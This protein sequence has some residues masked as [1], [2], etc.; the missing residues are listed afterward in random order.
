MPSNFGL[1]PYHFRCRTE[2]IP[3]WIDEYEKNGVKMNATT[4]PSESEI[5]RHID[6]IGVERYVNTKNPNP[7]SKLN[8]QTY[9]K[10][11]HY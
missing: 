1:P 10:R 9:V 5:L 8:K 6:K 4:A 3:V 7:L 11:R 2:L